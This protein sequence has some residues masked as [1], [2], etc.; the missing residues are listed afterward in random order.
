MMFRVLALTSAHRQECPC[1]AFLNSL[2]R[3]MCP[4]AGNELTSWRLQSYFNK[5]SVRALQVQAEAIGL[6]KG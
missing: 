3:L 6:R 1:L 2:L 4:G 5:R